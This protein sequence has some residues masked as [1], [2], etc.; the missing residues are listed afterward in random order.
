MK[1]KKLGHQD[2]GS[3][4]R[5]KKTE[6]VIKTKTETSEIEEEATIKKKIENR[7]KQRK[8]NHKKSRME[9]M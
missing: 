3:Q 8:Q 9:E 1:T 5:R 2:T 7:Q 6:N 4:Q